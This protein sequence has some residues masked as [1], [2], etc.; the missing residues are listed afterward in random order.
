MTYAL[1]NK[2]IRIAGHRGM[3]GIAVERRVAAEK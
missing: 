3:V 1:T 2:R